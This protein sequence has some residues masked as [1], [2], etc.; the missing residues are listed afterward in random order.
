VDSYGGMAGHGGG[1]F[2]GKDSTKVD[3]SASYMARYVAK[4]IVASGVAS[5]VELQFS[6][7]IGVPF[8]VTVMVD[9]FGTGHVDDGKIAQVVQD[10]FDLSPVGIENTL[11][12]R[13]PMYRRTTNYG[14]FGREEFSWE[15]TDKAAAVKAALS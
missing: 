5:R 12:L 7:A 4:N 1:A 3:R 13:Q 15:K 8:P 2:S 9:S 14:H 6:Y 11:G 10:L